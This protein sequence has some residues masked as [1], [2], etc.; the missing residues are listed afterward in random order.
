MARFDVP[1][2]VSPKSAIFQTFPTWE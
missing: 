1:A 2:D